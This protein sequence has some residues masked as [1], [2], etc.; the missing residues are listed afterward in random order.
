MN[1][2]TKVFSYDQTRPSFLACT[3]HLSCMDTYQT[4]YIKKHYLMRST[5]DLT[6]RA[7]SQEGFSILQSFVWSATSY[8]AS[9]TVRASPLTSQRS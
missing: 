1:H 8:H 5:D 2:R 6:T 7:R 4:M 3:Q 9:P